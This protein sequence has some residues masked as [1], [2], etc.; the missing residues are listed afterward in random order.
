MKRLF[1]RPGLAINRLIPGL[2]DLL[3]KSV[4]RWILLHVF[5]AKRDA[6]VVAALPSRRFMHDEL[7]P[8]LREHYSR[9]LFVG[10]AA[11]TY[12]Y[13]D[14]FRARPGQFTTLD[15]NPSA[16]V[17][18]A[19]DHL[20]CPIQEI[21]RW[22]AKGAFDC[23]VM[24]GVLGF[25]VNDPADMRMV[26]KAV[27]GVL[28]PGGLLVVGWNVGQHDDPDTLGIYEPYFAT[29]TAL[30]WCR[31]V[32]FAG[33]THVNDFHVRRPVQMSR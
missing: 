6:D 31:R 8:W 22:R 14:L 4:H 2:K 12:D 18:G 10:T 21:G 9:I 3:P 23:I 30:P 26:M 27:H 20:V 11:Y 24:N 28:E 16:A 32:R 13:E 17:W 7:L 19:S 33:E 29:C 1:V 25:G 15:V 5:G